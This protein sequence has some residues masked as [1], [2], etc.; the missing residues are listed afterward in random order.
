MLGAVARSPWL[1]VLALSLPLPLLAAGAPALADAVGTLAGRRL[2]AS[3]RTSARARPPAPTPLLL[4]ALPAHELVALP[5]ARGA[6]PALAPLGLPAPARALVP[7]KGVRVRAETVLRLAN[8]GARPGGF[9]VPAQGDRPRGL[10]LTGVSGLGIGLEDGDILTHAAGRPAL[11]PGDVIG[12]VIGSRTE[13]AP[14][15]WGRFWRNG[16]PWSLV[17]EQ[18]YPRLKKRPGSLPFATG[19]T[20]RDPPTDRTL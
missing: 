18:P 7:K 1:L 14:E 20:Q 4:E 12:V 2:A 5:A 15:I 13:R 6:A 9:P 3:T 11:T 16:E 19:S 10:A 8:S 17:V